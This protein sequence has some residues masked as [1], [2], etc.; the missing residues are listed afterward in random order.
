M[1]DFNKNHR[2]ITKCIIFFNILILLFALVSTKTE[3][4]LL[5]SDRLV[6]VRNKNIY[7][8]Q[9]E[10]ENSIDIIVLGDSLS[11]SAITPMRL[12]KRYGYTSYVCGQSGQKIDE[13][14]EM[15]NTALKVQSPEIVIL[16]TNTLF[17]SKIRG[18]RLNKLLEAMMNYYIPVF[19]GHDVWK[20]LVMKKEYVEENYKGFAFRCAVNPYE[21][22]DYMNKTDQVKRMSVT[23]REYLDR[24][25]D[26]CQENDAEFLLV[27][28]PSPLNCTYEKHNAIA[29]YAKNRGLEYLDMNLFLKD[30]G[31]DWKT[32]SLDNGDHLNLS[33]AERVTEYLGQYLHERY[34][35]PDHREDGAYTAWED[36][37]I[38]Y[39]QKASGYL[40]EIRKNAE[41]I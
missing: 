21:K 2:I 24:I 41:S 22:G 35:I 7:R 20:S 16:E 3:E 23:V 26:I 15:L 39:E 8:I 27:S 10:P 30:I 6:P 5:N 4:A 31:M 32:D 17:D 40:K 37:S 18:M 25:A 29:E 19:R 36:E 1:Q 33:G 14:E 11:Y 28:T 34:K 38:I 9:R 12:W 13:T